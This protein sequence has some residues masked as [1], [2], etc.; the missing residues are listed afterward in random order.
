MAETDNPVVAAYRK[1]VEKTIAALLEFADVPHPRCDLGGDLAGSLLTKLLSERY[2][3]AYRALTDR[4]DEKVETT[5]F[6]HA[7][8]GAQETP[9]GGP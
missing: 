4:G 2:P 3:D 9:R 5:S 7:I 6:G 1:D 8:R